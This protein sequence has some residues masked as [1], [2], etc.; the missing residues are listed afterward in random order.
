MIEQRSI[1]FLDRVHFDQHA[2]E[3]LHMPLVDPLVL[4]DL[5]FLVL[6]VRQLVVSPL[7]S[8]QKRKVAARDVIGKHERG[9][10]GRVGL[11]GQNHQVEHHLDVFAKV[12]RHSR[13][14]GGQR[15]GIDFR[16]PPSVM[17]R[18]EFNPFFHGP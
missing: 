8:I 15:I 14:G 12:L 4:G 7:D 10:T 3:L 11:E 1:T 16:F 17:R 13:C 9:D 18:R 6:V 5:F 2:S